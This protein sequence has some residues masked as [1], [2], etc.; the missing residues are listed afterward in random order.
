MDKV[1]KEEKKVLPKEKEQE[2]LQKVNIVEPL[3]YEI[4]EIEEE[5]VLPEKIA[6]IR[7]RL[8]RTL[9]IIKE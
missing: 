2:I 9:E 5:F 6:L 3:I 4:N 7:N 8:I 1:K